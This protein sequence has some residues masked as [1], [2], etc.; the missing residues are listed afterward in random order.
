MWPPLEVATAL[1]PMQHSCD[2]PAGHVETLAELAGRQRSL[3][4]V[5][6]RHEL[7]FRDA[8]T[9]SDNGALSV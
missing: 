7:G 1:E 4:E 5:D 8:E 9:L 2:A 3:G 6:E